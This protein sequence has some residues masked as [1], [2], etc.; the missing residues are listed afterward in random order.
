ME[1]LIQFGSSTPDKKKIF[2]PVA[3]TKAVEY[4]YRLKTGDIEDSIAS[5]LFSLIK[6]GK[7]KLTAGGQFVDPTEKEYIQMYEAWDKLRYEMFIQLITLG[8][9]IIKFNPNKKLVPVVVPVTSFHIIR[10]ARKLVGVYNVDT[11]RVQ[12]HVTKLVFQPYVNPYEKK[13]INYYVF[14]G[15]GYDP[16]WDGTLTSIMAKI[17]KLSF[18]HKHL[19]LLHLKAVSTVSDPRI[20]YLP[21]ARATSRELLETHQAMDIHNAH[22]NE[23]YPDEDLEENSV[24]KVVTKR[25]LDEEA[26]LELSRTVALDEIEEVEVDFGFL[27]NR[28]HLRVT[29]LPSGSGGTVNYPLPIPR[30]QEELQ[31]SLKTVYQRVCNAFG[32]PPNYVSGSTQSDR[33]AANVEVLDR[34]LLGT[35]NK[36]HEIFEEIFNEIYNLKFPENKELPNPVSVTFLRDQRDSYDTLHKK[37]EHNVLTNVEFFN[38]VRNKMGLPPYSDEEAEKAGLMV[39]EPQVPSGGKVVDVKKE[40]TEMQKKKKEKRKR[41]TDKYV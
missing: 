26:V 28:Q 5:F 35:L 34:T 31:A 16:M 14:S 15:F 30:P 2:L 12:Y 21:D 18:F 27:R 22:V 4:E 7:M 20:F 29:A 6:E 19:N 8:M 41:Q 24:R 25:Q 3:T 36:W 10:V 32:I 38:I 23:E 33:F 17:H 11:C 37:W 9:V 1:Q 13:A 39:K 40:E